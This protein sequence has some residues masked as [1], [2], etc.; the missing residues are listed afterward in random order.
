MLTDDRRGRSVDLHGQ[1]N[2][3]LTAC[4]IGF[5]DQIR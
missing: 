3:S 5:L 2:G 4:N 1:R